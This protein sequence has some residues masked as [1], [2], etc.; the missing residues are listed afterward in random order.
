MKRLFPLLLAVAALAL[1]GGC[2]KAENDP[3]PPADATDTEPAADDA[4]A[5]DD[6]AAADA[7]YVTL[8]VPNMF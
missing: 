6:E 7:T 5:V 3:A 8:K 1:Y 4:A 2:Q